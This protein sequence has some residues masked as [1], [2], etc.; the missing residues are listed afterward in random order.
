MKWGL[1]ARV[2]DFIVQNMPC[3]RE[4]DAEA[5]P[6]CVAGHVASLHEKDRA[7]IRE[8]RGYPVRA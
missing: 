4:F 8:T 1:P 6:G 5:V 2:M 3:R 7:Y